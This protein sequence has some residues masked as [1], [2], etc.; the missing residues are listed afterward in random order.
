MFQSLAICTKQLYTVSMDKITNPHDS[1]FRETFSRIEIATDFLSS[2]LPEP[3]KQQIDLD[4]LTMSKDSFVDKELRHHFSDILYTVKYQHTDLH[5]YL[6]FEHKSSPDHWIALQV[7]RYMVRI[8]EQHRKQQPKAKHLP[9]I[10]PL[11]LYHGRS[12]WKISKKFSTLLAPADEFVKQYTPDFQYLL[13]DFSF[14]SNDQIRGKTLASITLLAL[15]H[16]FNPNLSD[17][18]PE[19]INLLQDVRSKQTALEILEILLR[20]IVKGTNRFTEKDI[21]K[22]LDRTSM[23]NNIMKTFIDE[24]IEQGMRQGMQK[25]MQKGTQKINNI[26]STQLIHRFGT[27]PQWAKEKIDRADM[28]TLEKWSLQLLSAD[29]L[30]EVFH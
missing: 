28:D 18:L 11:V 2:Y 23:E 22:I 7:L 6:L 19:I 12:T 13:H 30:D 20:Y 15:K 25:G 16:I 21:L 9:V 10:I 3:I 4:T 24:Y 8:W 26:L 5:L 29:K 1:F 17:K 14:P 27:L